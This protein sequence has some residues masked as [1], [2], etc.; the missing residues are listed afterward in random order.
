[1]IKGEEWRRLGSKKFDK[2]YVLIY[3]IHNDK[4][5]GKYAKEFAYRRGLPL[6]RVSQNFHQIL[7]EGKFKYLPDLVE[8]LSLIDNAECLIT[9]SFH[10]TAFAINLNTEFVEIL[11]NTNT[12]SRNMSILR[13]LGLTNRI[14]NDMSY[15]SLVDKGIDYVGVNQKLDVEREKSFEI[16]NSFIYE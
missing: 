8:F 11:P 7:R 12:S 10:G 1:M 16:L 14:V 5:I 3:Q 4:R 13:L 6:I 9:D 2:K 15:F